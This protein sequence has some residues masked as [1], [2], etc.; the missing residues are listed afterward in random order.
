[1]ALT[2]A[3]VKNRIY[4]LFHWTLIICTMC[5]GGRSECESLRVLLCGRGAVGAIPA[6][7]GV[8]G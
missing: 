3:Q 8:S 7:E 2:K 4:L 1:M 6:A 5:L